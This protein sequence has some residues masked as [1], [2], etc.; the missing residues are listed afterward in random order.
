VQDVTLEDIDLTYAE[1]SSKDTAFVSPDSLSAVPEQEANYP[2]F[3]MFGEL[4]ASGF[5]ARHVQGLHLKNWRIHYKKSDFRPAVIFDDVSE[6]RIG[7]IDIAVSA[8][9]P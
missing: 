8:K 2:E 4:P 3:S 5:Y 6:I 9:L 7:D 1:G